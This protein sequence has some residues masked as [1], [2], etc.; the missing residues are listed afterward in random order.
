MA[1][2]ESVAVCIA[3]VPLDNAVTFST[4]VVSAREYC[5]VKVRSTDGIE[6]VGYCYAVNTSGRLLSVAV[7]DLLGARLIG[8]DSLRVEGLWQE[9]YQEALLQGRTGAVMRALSAIDI[10]VWDLSARTA[11]LPLYQYLGAVVKDRVPAYASGG[12]YLPGKTPAKLG[13]ELAGYVRDGFTAVKMKTGR[14]SP[15]EEEERVRAAREAIGRD[16]LLML[17]ANNAWHD[18]PTALR[19][20]ERFE[21]YDP[22]W[23]EEPFSPDDLENHARL[24]QRT[25][26][27]VATGEIE[28]GRWRFKEMLD[29]G[30]AGI[31]QT[32]ATVCGGVSEWRRI[33]ATAASYGVTV[34][35]HAWHDV[36]VHLAASAPNAGY[37][38]FMPDDHI[39]NF[40]RL[41]DRQ[42]VAE[43]G[44]LLLPQTPGLGFGFD[45]AA[46]AKYGTVAPGAE[47]VWQVVR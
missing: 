19:Y 16:V 28:A 21:P 31:L 44:D 14:L 35:P 6:G 12:Y 38:E 41:I 43:K 8:E 17:D 32:D 23:I 7:T 45:P 36:H 18:L 46:V 39:V 10:A 3:R 47:G 30:A 9:M 11:R 2:I 15:G 13:E 20:M 37:V 24:A 27:T 26:V 4:R 42:L 34:S 40:R 1:K 33:A 5:L 29:K 22:Y 25:R